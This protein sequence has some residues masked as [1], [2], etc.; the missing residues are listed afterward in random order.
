MKTLRNPT[1]GTVVTV[2]EAEAEK[3][4]KTGWTYTSR[5]ELKRQAAIVKA[6]Q[7]KDQAA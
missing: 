7:Q 3:L 2:P 5:Y 1:T 4:S 6:K